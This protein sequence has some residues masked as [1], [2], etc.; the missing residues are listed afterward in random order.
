MGWL[1]RCVWYSKLIADG[2]DQA[3]NPARL[4]ARALFDSLANRLESRFTSGF[5]PEYKELDLAEPWHEGGAGRKAPL[6]PA[7]SR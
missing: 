2:T 5:F 1:M 4:M 3:L 7:F 6:F